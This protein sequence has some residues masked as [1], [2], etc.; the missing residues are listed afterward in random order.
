MGARAVRGGGQC[1]V[2]A[3]DDDVAAV[4]GPGVA[5]VG[6]A[7]VAGDVVTARVVV[8]GATDEER[9]RDQRE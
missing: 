5:G 2:V 9:E 3:A 7:T 6:H 4:A 8:A 1:G